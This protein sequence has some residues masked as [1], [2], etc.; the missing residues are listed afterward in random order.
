MNSSPCS[1]YFIRLYH[2]YE[3][4]LLP[5]LLGQDQVRYNLYQAEAKY[6]EDR[7]TGKE[8]LIWYKDNS[9]LAGR[10]NSNNRH[11]EHIV[12]NIITTY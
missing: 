10:M 8:L 9:K 1:L 5:I 12:M 6:I 3:Y 2:S 7:N 11:E 4:Q